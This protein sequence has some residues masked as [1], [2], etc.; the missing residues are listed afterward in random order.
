LLLAA[1]C[2]IRLS[3]RSSAPPQAGFRKLNL[4]TSDALLVI[5]NRPKTTDTINGLRIK[6][7]IWGW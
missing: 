1:Y 7:W 5:R 4:Q 6:R 3:R 2:L